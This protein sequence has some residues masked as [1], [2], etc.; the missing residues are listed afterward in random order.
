MKDSQ[1]VKHLA[2]FITSK[3]LRQECNEYMDAIQ[4]NGQA[5]AEGDTLSQ[6]TGR[7]KQP[8]RAYN[9]H[10]LPALIKAKGQPM[11]VHAIL[12]AYKKN[13]TEAGLSVDMVT[14]ALIAAHCKGNAAAAKGIVHIK[15]TT[16]FK[17]AKPDND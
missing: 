4:K 16:T 14:P 6:L 8:E 17:Y 7:K 3:N 5:E 9:T 15:G 10:I 12:T 2:A 13:A 11:D 1:T